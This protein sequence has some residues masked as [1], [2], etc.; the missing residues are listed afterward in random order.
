LS[1]IGGSIGEKP[2]T[3]VIAKVT[4]LINGKVSLLADTKLTDRHDDALT[5]RTLSNPCQKVVIVNNDVVVGFAGDTPESALRVLVRLRDEGV[6]EIED[7][8]ISF[9]QE[10]SQL[11][12]VSKKI[13]LVRRR[14]SLR[15]VVIDNGQPDDRTDIGTGWI[16]DSDAF[17]AFS[18]VFQNENFQSM[19]RH[20]QRLV[21]AMAYLIGLEDVE[22]VGGYMV[23]VTG[24]RERAFRFQVDPG[25]VMPWDLE[26]TVAQHSEQSIGLTLSLPEGADPTRHTR[27]PVPGKEPTYGALAHYIPEGGVAWLHTHEEPWRDPQRLAVKSLA[28]LIVR[29]KEEHDQVLNPE[30]AQYAID[31]YLR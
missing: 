13:L 30:V 31:Q 14:P 17:R 22:S 6:E 18:A 24:D 3:F 10:M 19:A 29:A 5:R 15:I 25:F 20:D 26:G 12:G 7:A 21:G 9:S 4:D 27:I 1:R 2:V 8:L 16:G 11:E 28:D 23:R